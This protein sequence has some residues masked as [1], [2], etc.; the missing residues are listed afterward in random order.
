[1]RALVVAVIGIVASCGGGG[2]GA[3][4]VTP[5]EYDAAARVQVALAD[6]GPLRLVKPPQGGYVSFVGARVEGLRAPLVQMDAVVRGR[7]GAVIARS[8]RV[9]TLVANPR[10][11]SVREPD[12]GELLAFVHVALCPPSGSDGRAGAR[13]TLELAV[14]ELSTGRAA[15]ATRDLTLACMQVDPGDRAACE[16]TCAGDYRLGKCP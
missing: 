5:T 3:L 12:V 14:T 7:D 2:D 8:M 6:G 11:P 13:V 16:C 15:S 9:A 10:A 1:M 4:V